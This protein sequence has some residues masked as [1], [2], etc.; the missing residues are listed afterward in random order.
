MAD[1]RTGTRKYEYRDLS[2]A[3]RTVRL[4]VASV[5]MTFL[6]ELGKKTFLQTRASGADEG[7]EFVAGLELGFEDSEHS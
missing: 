4:S 5:E 3:Q 1:K 2:T 7:E 6:L